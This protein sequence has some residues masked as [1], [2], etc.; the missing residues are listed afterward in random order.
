MQRDDIGVGGSWSQF[1]DYLKSSLSS[2][3]VKL[4]LGGL[5]NVGSGEPSRPI[6]IFMYVFCIKLI[7]GEHQRSSQLMESLSSER[8]GYLL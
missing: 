2:R 8:V 1:V 7:G 6:N 4:I 3:D 5:Q